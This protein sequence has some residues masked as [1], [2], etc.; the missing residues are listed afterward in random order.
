M[1][2]FPFHLGEIHSVGPRTRER[3]VGALQ[4]PPMIRFGLGLAGWSEARAGF[5]FVRPH[6]AAGQLLACHQGRGEVWHDGHWVGLRPGTAYVTPPGAPHAYRA[7]GPGIWRVYWA[8]YPGDGAT[9]FPFA[10]PAVIPVEVEPL[11]LAI[12]GL[13]HTAGHH[14]APAEVELWVKLI[15]HRVRA[16]VGTSPPADA[17]LARLWTAVN[18]D[19]A[20]PWTLAE[21]ARRAALSREALRR[22]CLPACGHSPM[23]EVSRLRMQRAAELLLHTHDKVAAIALRV[24]FNDPFAFSTAFKRTHGFT[25]RAYRQRQL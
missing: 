3:M 16:A 4:A 15:H 13:C 22:L 7:R 9:V 18:D 21:L 19:L 25:P 10:A 6:P 8:S 20:H 5:Q 23:R 24:G 2:A 14:P 11:R 12:E 1:G 17:R